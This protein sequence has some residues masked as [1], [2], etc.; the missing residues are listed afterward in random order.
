MMRV[1]TGVVV[2]LSLLQ[3]FHSLEPGDCNVSEEV[4]EEVLDLI[5][6]DRRRGFLFELLCVADVHVHQTESALV[7]YLVLDVIESDCSVL[8]RVH[9]KDCKPT[10]SRRRPSELVIGQCKVIATTYPNKSREAGKLNGYNCTTSSVSSALTDPR[11]TPPVI[12]D[13]F[14]NTEEYSGQAEKALDKYISES[15]HSTLFKVDRV[16]RAARVRGGERTAYFVDFSITSCSKRVARHPSP[17]HCDFVGFCNGDLVYSA[18]VTNLENPENLEVNCEIFNNTKYLTNSGSG[19]DH[20]P[21]H[22]KNHR[23]RNCTVSPP[24]GVKPNQRNPTSPHGHQHHRN[25]QQRPLPPNCPFHLGGPLAPQEGQDGKQQEGDDLSLHQDA[26]SPWG[27]QRN[28]HV[29]K[30]GGKH[31]PRHLSHSDKHKHKDS[32]SSEEDHSLRR[33]FL[34]PWQQLGYV[35]RLPPLKK[36][37]VLPVPEVNF[38][39][40]HR[41]PSP[42][43]DEP[44]RPEI[45]PFPQSPSTSCPGKLKYEGPV[46][47]FLP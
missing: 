25:H 31:R 46:S 1:L 38:P 4:A 14:E 45:P 7:S 47:R 19:K 37:E 17:K 26:P 35:Y 39:R 12:I 42:E 30:S 18:E 22:K 16:E 44:H 29:S 36:D 28:G 6:K 40:P 41:Y 24:S 43:R 8:T 21:Y 3:H 11:A 2:F 34:S 5:N 33:R 10:S 32:H 23:F 20:H 13:Y 27:S 15:G 9:W